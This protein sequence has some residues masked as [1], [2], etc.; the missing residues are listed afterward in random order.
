VIDSVT[1][2][3]CT[4]SRVEVGKRQTQGI[5]D[6]LGRAAGVALEPHT[7]I[8]MRP[9]FKARMLIRMGRATCRPSSLTFFYLLQEAKDTI[10]RIFGHFV[11]RSRSIVW[12]H[13]IL[14]SLLDVEAGGIDRSVYNFHCDVEKIK[15]LIQQPAFCFS[16]A[17]K[18]SAVFLVPVFILVR[19]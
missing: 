6:V 7:T 16:L 15:W 13:H 19:G 12:S 9:D 1:L 10:Q 11:L 17:A 3:L 5:D 18:Q 4:F 2:C 14:P 8:L